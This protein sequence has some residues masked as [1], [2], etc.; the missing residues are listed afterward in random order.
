MQLLPGSFPGPGG[1]RG[2]YLAAGKP[3]FNAEYT[4][5][6]ETTSRFCPADDHWG[7]W[8]ALFSVDLNGPKLYK[9]CW[10]ANDSPSATVASGFSGDARPG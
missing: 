9:V 10:N 3:V 5:D 8:G 1:D 4:Q 2:P 7:I 6:G